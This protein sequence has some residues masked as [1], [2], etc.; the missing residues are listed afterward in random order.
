M[1]RTEMD[2]SMKASFLFVAILL[3]CVPAWCADETVL[4]LTNGGFLP[5]ELK[6]SEQPN[7]LRWK[8]ALFTQPFEF[9][10][11]NVGAIYFTVPATLPKPKGEYCLE[12]A[13]GDVLFGELLG[14]TDDA[15]ELDVARFGRLHVR[16]DQ[17]RRLDRWRGGAELIYL[18]PN[19]LTGWKESSATT[20]WREE[21][22]QLVTDKEGANIHGDFGIPAQA[23]I[24][25]ELSWKNKADFVLALGVNG[26]DG[27]AVFKRAYRLE[28]W[29]NVL[30]VCCELAH[31]AD[32]AAV[33]KNKNGAGRI[34]LLVYLDQEKGTM[35][36]YSPSGARLVQISVA[37][38]RMLVYSGLRLTN[39]QGDVRLERLRISRWN[40]VPPPEA[41]TSKPRLHRTDG[42]IV[43]GKLAGF[44]AG[45]K[46]FAVRDGSEETK[47]AAD[48]IASVFFSAPDDTASRAIRAVYQDGTQISG[49]LTQIDDDHLRLTRSGIQEPL[50]L[51]L[52]ELRS[53]VVLQRNAL[54][55]SSP[56]EG[57]A[58]RL[59]LDGL[60]LP[61]RLVNGQERPDASCLVW[62]P[63]HS[64]TASPLRHGIAGRIVYRDPPPP[65]PKPN[66]Q[67]ST[68]RQRIAVVNGLQV[69]PNVKRPP[70]AS[71][72]GPKILHLRSGDTIPC[73][74][75]KIDES[76]ITLKT[77]LS[78][79]MFVKHDKVKAV[80]LAAGQ[81]PPKLTKAKRERLLTLPRAQRDSPPTHLIL[82][83]NGDFLRGRLIDMDDKILHVEIRLE[84]REVPR[85]RVAQ[86]I[87]LHADE[88][89]DTPPSPSSP[90]GS[91]RA[92]RVQVVRS[93]GNRL[94][95][96]PN[97]QA[98]QT[99]SG[100]S[101]VL[102]M[103]RTDL[104]QVDQLL[105]GG[106][107]ENAAQDL[108]YQR[109]KLRY[110]T[111]PKIAQDTDGR[112]PT[113]RTP[114]TDSA[115]VGKPAPDFELD[116]L[117]GKRF[118]LTNSKG[119]IVVLDFWA[120]W[121]GPCLQAM[122]QVD[123][124]I[125]EFSDQDVQL[126]AV[127]LEEPV[128]QITSTLERHKLQMSVALDRD[129]VVAAKYEATAIP[130]TVII[131][132]DGKVNRLFVG[133][134]PHLAEEL[135]EALR[136]LVSE[137]PSDRPKL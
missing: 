42:S 117:G 6:G 82:S 66:L 48:Q 122:P 15:V 27:E 107:I 96:F 37:T 20:Q 29:D 23:L 68:Q 5:G 26:G 31:G 128:K 35:L 129:G 62:H 72:T 33:Q 100:M 9:S 115:L 16:R 61:G 73:D 3:A 44:D 120:T 89:S 81:S 39:K 25:F 8:S 102:G 76:G 80:E 99:L 51:P 64:T 119:R 11:N 133:G 14:L 130:Q 103:C 108:V 90:A 111:E 75:T 91:S 77:P 110:A 109:W 135:R 74:V 4:H 87:L 32:V 93:D 121:C 104:A 47:V 83:K 69:L 78:D 52:S 24:E 43:Y 49:E 92:T 101:D 46:Q 137:T 21:G 132:R 36:V 136:K 56:P 13:G 94:T 105:I 57:I 2:R 118:R 55:A 106:A 112:S 84:T 54:P 114:G 86:I 17:I 28:A 113:G 98:D 124:V 123:R 88:L 34:H 126:I 85:D 131:D 59:E 70:Q 12:L 67:Q 19:G 1:R 97:Q 65:Q 50:R 63:D 95:F 10:M 45:T 40:G 125:R 79:A 22:G 116:L 18:G 41:Q 58:G 53:L 38:F 60:R 127:N 134:G 7:V 71:P 30:V